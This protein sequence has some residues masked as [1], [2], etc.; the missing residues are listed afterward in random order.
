MLD[1]HG[2]ANI[3][4]V[5]L[6]YVVGGISWGLPIFWGSWF[7]KKILWRRVKVNWDNPVMVRNV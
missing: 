3:K 4:E 1:S 2:T 6:N 7:K 5:R